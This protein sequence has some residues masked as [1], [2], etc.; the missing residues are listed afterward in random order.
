MEAFIPITVLHTSTGYMTVTCPTEPTD[1]TTSPSQNKSFVIEGIATVKLAKLMGAKVIA[2]A[3]SEEKLKVCAAEGADHTICYKDL[4]AKA[5]RDAVKATGAK[6]DVV[7]D[8]VGGPM[9]EQ[10]KEP[11]LRNVTVM[12]SLYISCRLLG[13]D[14]L[15]LRDICRKA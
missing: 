5:V 8:M 14:K 12:T 6:P 2:L 13:T 11:V 1:L 7:V 3:G 10:C 4:D 9:A 15:L